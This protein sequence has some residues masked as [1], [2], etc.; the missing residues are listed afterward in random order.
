VTGSDVASARSRAGED[1]T[2]IK[3]AL[4]STLGI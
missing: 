4:S 3:Q 1:L 2:G